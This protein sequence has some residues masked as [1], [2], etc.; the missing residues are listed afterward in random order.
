VNVKTYK[1]YSIC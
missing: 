1:I